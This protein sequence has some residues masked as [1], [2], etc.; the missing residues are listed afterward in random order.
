MVASLSGKG[1]KKVERDD[2]E[3]SLIWV[4]TVKAGIVPGVGVEVEAEPACHHPRV[5]S[6]PNLFNDIDG[7]LAS[8][9]HVPPGNLNHIEFH[10]ICTY[11]SYMYWI[12]MYPKLLPKPIPS[13]FPNAIARK[14]DSYRLHVH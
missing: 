6:S 12:Y 4:G 14:T 11:I 1:N 10:S 2:S 5:P 7:C 9:I 8:M 13:F 3:D